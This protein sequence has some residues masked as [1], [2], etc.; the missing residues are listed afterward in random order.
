MAAFVST[1]VLGIANSCM[2]AMVLSTPLHFGKKLCPSSTSN[3]LIV[4]SMGE[5]SLS[6]IFG[7]GIKEFGPKAFFV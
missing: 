7:Y 5:G 2:Y 4:A 1:V 6:G 3:I